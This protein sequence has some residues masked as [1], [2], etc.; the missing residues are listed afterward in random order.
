MGDSNEN[1]YFEGRSLSSLF[2]IYGSRV[3]DLE[4]SPK[5]MVQI[6]ESYGNHLDND[7]V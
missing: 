5:Y 3:P 2:T 1:C 4:G 7:L 6:R